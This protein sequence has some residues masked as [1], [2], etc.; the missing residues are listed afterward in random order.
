MG[1]LS[2]QLI[3]W[4]F[5]NRRQLPWRDINDP[6]RIWVSEII[7]QQTRV[8]QGMRYYFRFIEAFPTLAD[9]AEADEMEV[10]KV[11]QGLG[12]YSR[13]R[14][15]LKA[16]T[17][18]LSEHYAKFPVK[19][20]D[21]VKLPGIGHYTAAAIASLAGNEPMPA[22]DGNVQ[23]AVS[24]LFGIYDPVNSNGMLRKIREILEKEIDRDRPGDFNQAMIELGA[25]LC[26]PS[27][28]DCSSCVLSD[29][30]YAFNNNKVTELP[31]KGIKKASRDRYFHYLVLRS[32]DDSV[33][34][35]QRDERDVWAKLWEFPLVES[36]TPLEFNSTELIHR[37]KK[38]LK[39]RSIHFNS[40]SD[41]YVHKLSHLNIHARF[42]LVETRSPE[43]ESDITY[44]A[45]TAIGKIHEY[46]TSRLIE[47]FM[48]SHPEWFSG[49]S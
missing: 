13:A 41:W 37:A 4:Y 20:D 14:N 47:Q 3:S 7:L 12:Y 10:L 42:F 33:L 19:Y 46:P 23:R 45:T 11:W 25:T 38:L 39:V 17:I 24:R 36:N 31:V 21:L 43:E 44:D 40:V 5:K 16:A 35:K 18:I 1:R 49:Q 29:I 27:G 26:V 8:N 9:L 6:Y 34:L 22:I 32:D 30:C 28:P 2:K 48:E 15:M